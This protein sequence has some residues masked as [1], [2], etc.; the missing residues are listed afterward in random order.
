EQAR[1]W[2]AQARHDR[3][4]A[5]R[6]RRGQASTRPD[7]E[8]CARDEDYPAALFGRGIVRRH[9]AGAVAALAVLLILRC[10]RSEPRRMQARAPRP[11][12]SRLGAARRA[13]QREELSQF[14]TTMRG[15]LRV[16][17]SSACLTM[18]VTISPA[19]G[20]S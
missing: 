15:S 3:C 13:P 4:A 18:R 5:V 17:I 14:F 9:D 1:R 11:R 7:V 16:K 19:G 12:P 2:P 6:P 8:L 20:M 10:E